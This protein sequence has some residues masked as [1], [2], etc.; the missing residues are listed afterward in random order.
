MI[1]AKAREKCKALLV[2]L[3]ALG[4]LPRDILI[5]GVLVLASLFSFSLGYLAGADAEQGKNS[6]VEVRRVE[7]QPSVTAGQRIVASK[8]GTR[9]YFTSCSGMSRITEANRVWFA[10]VAEA[11]S[12]GYTLAT[13]CKAP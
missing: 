2:R 8:S 12:A 11:E 10:T 13:N 4:K 7:I 1:I 9:Y 3:K 5:F 6:K